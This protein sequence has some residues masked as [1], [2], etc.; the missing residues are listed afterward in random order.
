MNLS[1]VEI[2]RTAARE[3]AAEYSRAAKNLRD[4]ATRREF[5]E[6]A[7]AYRL[8]AKDDIAL[9]AL[10]PTIVAGGTVTRTRVTGKG[11]AR[12]RRTNYLLPKLAACRS[13]ARFVYSKGVQ[14]NGAV[15]FVDKLDAR[16][17]YQSGRIGLE[18]ASFDLPHAYDAGRPI[19]RDWAAWSA[20]VP[21]VPPKALPR[22]RTNLNAYV[23]L[24][25][26][27][28]W[29]WRTPPRPPGDPALLQHLAGDLSVISTWD[30]T[31]LERLVLAG[32]RP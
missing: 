3:R 31:E 7:R 28:D 17:D 5:E 2:P 27:E 1:T 30:L 12:E 16:W 13:S 10:R 4:D 22:P 25:E 24:F 14:E 23:T 8:A 9:I 32:R 21:I 19:D 15:E 11:T 20:M 18:P 29:T 26:V 6:L